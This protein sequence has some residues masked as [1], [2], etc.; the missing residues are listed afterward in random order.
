ML[1]SPIH[2]L[3][4]LTKISL[5]TLQL[6]RCPNLSELKSIQEMHSLIELNLSECNQIR[7]ITP[8]QRM[9][10]LKK[11]DISGIR[12]GVIGPVKKLLTL[13]ESLEWINLKFCGLTIKNISDFL[14]ISPGVEI[15]HNCTR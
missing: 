11:L 8:I 5:S 6:N 2:S 15:L 14:E 4:F 1:N 13:S 12:C 10:S 9:V 7:D 3:S